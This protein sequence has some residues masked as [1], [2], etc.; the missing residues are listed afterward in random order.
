MEKPGEKIENLIRYTKGFLK[1]AACHLHPAGA[2]A[3]PV[4]HGDT[5]GYSLR[6][7]S[8][9]VPFPFLNFFRFRRSPGA[10][11][12]CTDASLRGLQAHGDGPSGKLHVTWAVNV[13][14]D[15]LLWAMH[16]CTAHYQAEVLKRILGHLYHHVV[17]NVNG[18]EGGS[19]ANRPRRVDLFIHRTKSAKLFGVFGFL[20]GRSMP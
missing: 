4:V 8:L 14:R 7:Y 20:C 11:P 15:E 3:Y 19:M 2:C 12:P 13:L 10:G 9:S 1:K 17:L 16:E 18:P 5:S 6:K